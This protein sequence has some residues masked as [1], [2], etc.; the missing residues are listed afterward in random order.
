MADKYNN[1]ARNH[2]NPGGRLAAAFRILP[3]MPQKRPLTGIKPTAGQFTAR[4]PKGRETGRI[5]LL[6]GCIA[7]RGTTREPGPCHVSG[8]PLII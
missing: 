2:H 3:Q 8:P 5:W 1:F 7:R 6:Y 4:E